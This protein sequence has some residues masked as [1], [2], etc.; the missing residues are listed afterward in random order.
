MSFK[1]CALVH[2]LNS[3]FLSHQNGW[4]KGVL[5]GR[6]SRELSS[7]SFIPL[8]VFLCLMVHFSGW[9]SLFASSATGGQ[10]RGHCAPPRSPC[11][12]SALGGEGRT[13]WAENSSQ[14]VFGAKG[15]PSRVTA[16]LRHWKLHP[17]ASSI[18][19]FK[20]QRRKWTRKFCFGLE[21][22]ARKDGRSKL[23]GIKPPVQ[24]C[25][26]SNNT[27]GDLRGRRKE[28]LEVSKLKKLTAL[29]NS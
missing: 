1:A 14:F 21:V 13:G 8:R 28:M 29:K 9:K 7:P 19:G 11:S 25:G 3:S 20:D 4:P 6:I 16:R 17:W 2:C 18:H 26:V 22:V 5:W 15:S 23:K 24:C 10:W 27:F 12:P